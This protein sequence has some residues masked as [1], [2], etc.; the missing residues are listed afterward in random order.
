MDELAGAQQ[1]SIISTGPF[2]AF[3]ASYGS[4]R[5]PNKPSTVGGKVCNMDQ[6]D[7][8]HNSRTVDITPDEE[9]VEAALGPNELP[10]VSNSYVVQKPLALG[11]LHNIQLFRNPLLQKL[12]THYV[13]DMVNVLP[14]LVHPENPYSAIFVPE[15]MAG[16]SD[17]I[18][19]LQCD[20]KQIPLANIAILNIL[21]SISAFHLRGSDGD[22][23]SKYEIMARG[24][25]AKALASLQRALDELVVT[26]NL[27]NKLELVPNCSTAP[28]E[29]LISA[30]YTLITS[31]VSG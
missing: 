8:A 1:Q 21:M 7:S 14:P 13:L 20:S 29:T 9:P 10:L 15:A 4:S 6:I 12:M 23:R 27:Q 22:G 28:V 16:A 24:F 18:F 3:R 26:T 2:G 17:L 19:G 5:R 11:P 30:V 25:R 31:D